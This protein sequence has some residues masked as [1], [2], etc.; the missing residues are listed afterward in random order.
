MVASCLSCSC[1]YSITLEVTITP[2][3]S[4][5]YGIPTQEWLRDVTIAFLWTAGSTGEA[6]AS[7]GAGQD[8]MNCTWWED[9]TDLMTGLGLAWT[10]EPD[11]NIDGIDTFSVKQLIYNTFAKNTI[12][13]LQLKET[14]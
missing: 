6:G 11:I 3:V 14:I 2:E 9:P 1:H 12:K 4:S 10:Q 13:M 7:T 8:N 5:T